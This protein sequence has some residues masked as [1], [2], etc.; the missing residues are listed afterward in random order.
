[1]LVTATVNLSLLS[2]E[3][4]EH[5]V[6]IHWYFDRC[7]LK[8]LHRMK[9][10]QIRN[11]LQRRHFSVS[12]HP[13]P[14]K[15]LFYLKVRPLFPECNSLSPGLG[16]SAENESIVKSNSTALV[17][18]VLIGHHHGNIVH[19]SSSD[20]PPPAVLEMIPADLRTLK[21]SFFHATE[22]GRCVCSL[23]GHRRTGLAAQTSA[24]SITAA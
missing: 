13:R 11:R 21:G 9:M 10:R 19:R 2:A 18:G 22:C 20:W 8:K 15:Y 14:L 17:T 3:N 5:F 1:M 23:Q 12:N 7:S 16:L 4:T 6:S 24:Y